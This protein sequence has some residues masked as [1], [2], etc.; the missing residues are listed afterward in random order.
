MSEKA[1]FIYGVVVVLLCAVGWIYT[2]V[3]VIKMHKE[4]G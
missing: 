1:L 4:K 3:E 2:V